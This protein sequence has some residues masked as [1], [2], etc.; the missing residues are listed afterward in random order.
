VRA[1]VDEVAET[2]GLSLLDLELMEFAEHA[3]L[4]ERI[5]RLEKQKQATTA[6]ASCESLRVQCRKSMRTLVIARDG[7]LGS[8]NGQRHPSPEDEAKKQAAYDKLAAAKLA[9]DDTGDELLH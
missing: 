7:G 4:R 1:L 9:D 2:G 5:K 6:I 8:P 3:N